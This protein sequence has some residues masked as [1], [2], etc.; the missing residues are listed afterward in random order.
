M[1]GK[2]KQ[3]PNLDSTDIDNDEKTGKH[4]NL[5]H[6]IPPQLHAQSFWKGKSSCKVEELTVNEAKLTDSFLAFSKRKHSTFKPYEQPVS[7]RRNQFTSG[8]PYREISK[9]DTCLLLAVVLSQ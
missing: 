5:G 8:S 1:E 7:K 9:S 4:K 6:E 3:I 2:V